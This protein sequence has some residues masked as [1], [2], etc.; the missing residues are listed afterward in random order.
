MADVES[1]PVLSGPEAVENGPNNGYELLWATADRFE[2]LNL[3]PTH[4]GQE[5]S[6]RAPRSRASACGTI[7]VSGRG[8]AGSESIR[9][10]VT[11]VPSAARAR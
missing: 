5:A 3:H 11:S 9:L 10:A 1:M 6:W 2:A 4:L 7:V 8:W